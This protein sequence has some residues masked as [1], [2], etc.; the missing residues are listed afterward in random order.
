M[1]SPGST[2]TFRFDLAAMISTHLRKPKQHPPPNPPAQG[3][4]ARKAE[5]PSPLEGSGGGWTAGSGHPRPEPGLAQPVR[6]LEGGDRRRLLQGEP[7]IVEAVQQAVLAEGVDVEF[8]DAA[9]G[10]GDR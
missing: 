6:R 3:G 1:P 4:R 5:S 9:I 8:D 2:R 10:P 7:D